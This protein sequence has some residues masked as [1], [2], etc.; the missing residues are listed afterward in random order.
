MIL[1]GHDADLSG[2]RNGF[3][4]F[5]QSRIGAEPLKTMPDFRK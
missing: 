2:L 3:K 1:I 4:T 5:E